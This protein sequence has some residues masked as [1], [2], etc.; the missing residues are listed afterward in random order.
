M[1]GI[2]D[3]DREACGNDGIDR[4]EDTMLTIIRRFVSLLGKIMSDA[5]E[6]ETEALLAVKV[7]QFPSRH[8]RG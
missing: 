6:A 8:R 3:G 4:K 2:A 1:R 7:R 5:R